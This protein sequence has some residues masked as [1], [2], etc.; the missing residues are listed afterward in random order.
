MVARVV[1]CRREVQAVDGPD[2][3]VI[4][5]VNFLSGTSPNTGSPQL[6]HLRCTA[7][8]CEVQPSEG[9]DADISFQ[10]RGEGISSSNRQSVHINQSR[11]VW[12]REAHINWS[13]V[14]C[15]GSTRL[16]LPC[17][18]ALLALLCRR[19]LSASV[20]NAIGTQLRDP[21]N[22]VGT[23]PMAD[24]GLNGYMDA[25]TEL[26][27]N[28]VSKHQIQPEYIDEQADAGRHCRTR[29][30]RPNSQARTGTVIN[31][32]SILRTTSRIGNLVRLIPPLAICD[33]HACTMCTA[34]PS[35]TRHGNGNLA[36]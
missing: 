26:G 5:P 15:L 34:R 14:T 11:R 31:H 22:S 2:I 30:A 20:N 19:G 36:R 7:I 6:G 24:G 25:A 13:M 35:T 18:R 3:R 29:L 9:M 21:I 27:R 28:P 16:E 4:I 8:N 12:E 10:Y 17:L 23:D 1:S 33:D 32:F